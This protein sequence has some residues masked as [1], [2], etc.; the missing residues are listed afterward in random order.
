M[1]TSTTSRLVR[2]ALAATVVV[3][4]VAAFMPR[5]A[6]AV[7]GGSW[8]MNTN[9]VRGADSLSST[10]QPGGP[11]AAYTTRTD[12]LAFL[13]SCASVVVDCW[14]VGA[15]KATVPFGAS[16]AVRPTAPIPAVFPA[17]ATVT[18]PNPALPAQPAL[19]APGSPT[20]VEWRHS[21]IMAA[22]SSGGYNLVMSFGGCASLSAVPA[23][24]DVVRVEWTPDD[25]SG[26]APGSG[27]VPGD[28]FVQEFTV[29][30]PAMPRC[31]PQ[32]PRINVSKRTGAGTPLNGAIMGIVDPATGNVVTVCQTG[33]VYGGSLAGNGACILSDMPPGTWVLREI[34][35]PAG[36]ARV[37]DRNVTFADF[38]IDLYAYPVNNYNLVDPVASSLRGCVTVD[39][40]GA[41]IAGV[42]ITVTDSSGWATT[43]TTGAD[44]CYQADGLAPG[45]ATVTQTQPVGYLPGVTNPSN[46]ITGNVVEGGITP[47]FDFSESLLID[48]Q[49]TKAVTSPAP[50]MPGSTITYEL[51]VSNSGPSTASAGWTVTEAPPSGLAITGMAGADVSCVALSC[52]GNIALVAGASAAPITVTATVAATFV[53]GGTLTNTA[54]VTAAPGDAPESDT[55]NNDGSATVIVPVSPMDLTLR[56]TRTSG[57]VAEAGSTATFEL[58]PSNLGPNDAAPGW[59]VTDLAPAGMTLLTMGGDGYSCSVAA[60]GTTGTCVAADGL[61]AGETGPTIAVTARIGTAVVAGDSLVNIAFIAPAAGDIAESNPLDDA[62]YGRFRTGPAGGAL[63]NAVVSPINAN[64]AATATNNDTSASVTIM[65][66]SSAPPAPAPTTTTAPAE[67]VDEPAEVPAGPPTGLGLGALVVVAALAGVAGVTRVGARTQRRRGSV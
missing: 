29:D 57:A 62:L 39:H 58:V 25:A 10:P 64:P 45:T 2:S 34:T 18:R 15:L 40:S 46:V 3:G 13:W 27:F 12:T 26:T 50:Y 63:T 17:A 35:P 52:V 24:T 61:D 67:P 43:A 54:A 4:S 60:D 66:I 19:N 33:A 32:F 6:A 9:Y 53:D 8:T 65:A 21:S 38:D 31:F 20:T 42:A 30:I 14:D 36:F 37:P 22:G 49:L 16:I 51:T 44:G 59:S 23:R 41:P 56:K 28:R 5:P 47:G 11:P 55:A 48:L 7:G 1:S